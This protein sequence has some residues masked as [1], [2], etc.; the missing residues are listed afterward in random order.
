MIVAVKDPAS[1]LYS[2]ELIVAGERIAEELVA[3][4]KV[5]TADFK[6]QSN[7]DSTVKLLYY[8]DVIF[9]WAFHILRIYNLNELHN[10]CFNVENPY[11]QNYIP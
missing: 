3:E 6:Q 11:S 1:R 2:K 8:G 4:F 7:I 10:L 5:T 9:S